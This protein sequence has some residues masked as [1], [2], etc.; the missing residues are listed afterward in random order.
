MTVP[1]PYPLPVSSGWQIADWIDQ[2][3]TSPPAGADGIA[4]VTLPQLAD[5]ERWQ[6]THMVCGCSSTSPTQMRLYRDDVANQNLRDGSNSGN[7][8]V[9]DWPGGL[10]IPPG[11]SMV[12]RWS[13]A[14]TNA[15]A[16]LTLQATVWRR[17]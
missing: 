12:A 17:R 15:V 3:F 10:W 2:Q 9:A 7:F 1:A 8:D 5:D 13:N 14:S 16:Y 6:L 11:H 4:L